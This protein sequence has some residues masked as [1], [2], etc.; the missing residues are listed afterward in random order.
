MPAAAMFNQLLINITF[1][2]NIYFFIYSSV[3]IPQ[4]WPLRGNNS[5][6][7]QG[8]FDKKKT[9]NPST[10]EN[11]FEIKRKQHI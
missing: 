4:K 2:K 7:G 1:K 9:R 11:F 10:P 3:K 8:H 6:N 5:V